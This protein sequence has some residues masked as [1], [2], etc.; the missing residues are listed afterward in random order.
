MYLRAIECDELNKKTHCIK[1]SNEC[2]LA[3]G[4]GESAYVIPNVLPPTA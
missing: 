3:R 1:I 4:I 2:V